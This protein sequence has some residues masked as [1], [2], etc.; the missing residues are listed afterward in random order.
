MTGAR[1]GEGGFDEFLVDP[2]TMVATLVVIAALVASAWA[3]VSG[4]AVPWLLAHQVLVPTQEALV[5]I[6]GAGGAGVDLRRLVVAFLM[7]VAV[8]CL[9]VWAVRSS[10]RPAASR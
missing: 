8:A 9:S 6:P 1:R 7:V 4:T 5:S 10:R 2:W 3:W